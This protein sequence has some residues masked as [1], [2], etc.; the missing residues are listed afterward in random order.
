MYTAYRNGRYGRHEQAYK[1]QTLQI[2]LAYRMA[3]HMGLPRE[4]AWPLEFIGRISVQTETHRN[5][6][7]LSIFVVFIWNYMCLEKELK[8]YIIIQPVPSRNNY[9]TGTNTDL[10]QYFFNFQQWPRVRVFESKVKNLLKTNLWPP[11]PLEPNLIK[12]YCFRFRLI[13]PKASLL[14]AN[15][16]GLLSMSVD[17]MPFESSNQQYRSTVERV[18]ELLQFSSGRHELPSCR[19]DSSPTSVPKKNLSDNCK[20]FCRPDALPVTQPPVLEH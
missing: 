10:N 18:C 2:N 9:F 15:L 17:Q 12:F 3:Y 14:K 19:L 16:L 13:R 11:S 1:V 5:Y 20:R 4:Q 7:F 8:Q 6:S